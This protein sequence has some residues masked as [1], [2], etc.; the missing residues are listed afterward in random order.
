MKTNNAIKET[1]AL[2][3]VHSRLFLLAFG[4]R[5][6]GN[7]GR[8]GRGG[9]GIRLQLGENFVEQRSLARVDFGRGL[10][11]PVVVIAVTSATADFGGILAQNGDY[12]VVH[13][14][15][16]LHAEVVDDVT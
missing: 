5:F 1:F 13:D 9:G 14:A 6:F 11:V 2:I 15:L 12:G 10:L 7:F 8:G 16:A 4:F 3:R